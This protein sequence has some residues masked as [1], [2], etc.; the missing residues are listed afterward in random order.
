MIAANVSGTQP[1]L[2]ILVVQPAR[3]AVSTIRN[4]PNSGA[5]RHHDHFHIARATSIPNNVVTNM[6]P[7]TATPY[8]EVRLLE[9]RKVSTN[10]TTH[11]N[12]NRFAAGTKI[13][14]RASAD[15]C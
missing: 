3:N 8:A 1:P 2:A 14:P 13:W 12:R 5:T 9:L 11:T 10:S 7:M 6:V 4:R 15:V